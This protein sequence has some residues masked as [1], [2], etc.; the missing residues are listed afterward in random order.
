MPEADLQQVILNGL[1]TAYIVIVTTITITLDD[2]SMK[3]FHAH[4]LAFESRL[5]S[6]TIANPLSPT[7]NVASKSHNRGGSSSSNRGRNNN[8]C[9]RANN[10]FGPH[11]P[12][13]PCQ[14]RGC[15]NHIA[16]TCWY[17]FDCQFKTPAQGSPS[18]AYVV[19]NN[20]AASSPF[21]DQNWYP[22]SGATNHVTSDLGNLSICLEY[23][24]LDQLCVGNG[25]GLSINHIG[26]T[27]FSS[28]HDTFLL[29]VIFHVP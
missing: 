23:N 1:N 22:D 14:L 6:Q 7:V 20:G 10:R 3:D 9:G 15:K 27:T 21:Y 18:S 24:G 28:D 16:E 25:A 19:V 5:Q 12:N 4:L 26:M 13:G 11:P 29:K 2:I 17:R 8:T